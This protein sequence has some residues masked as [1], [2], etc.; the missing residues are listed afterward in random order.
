MTANPEPHKQHAP[1]FWERYPPHI[2]KQI[3]RASLAWFDREMAKH[4]EQKQNEAQE[5]RLFRRLVKLLVQEAPDLA[6]V[7][8]VHGLPEHIIAH[9]RDAIVEP[10]RDTVVSEL[11]DLLRA[12]RQTARSGRQTQ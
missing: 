9:V 12:M 1:Y 7:L 3:E 10:I 4:K 2:A 5:R 8:R 11:P 6:D